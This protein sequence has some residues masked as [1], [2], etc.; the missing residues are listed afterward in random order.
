MACPPEDCGGIG[1]YF[2]ILEIKKNKKHPDYKQMIVEW[3][4]EDFDPERFSAEEVNKKL[5]RLK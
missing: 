5:A 3:L 1:G 2:D 4:G